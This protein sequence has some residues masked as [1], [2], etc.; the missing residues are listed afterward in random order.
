MLESINAFSAVLSTEGH[1]FGLC[2]AQLKPEGPD[3]IRKEAWW[4]Y[5][6]ISGVRLCWELEEPKGP[7]GRTLKWHRHFGPALP[8]G[9]LR[10]C[11]QKSTCIYAINFRAICGAHRVTLLPIFGGPRNIRCPPS[12]VPPCC[13]C[14]RIPGSAVSGR[15]LI[16]RFLNRQCGP[17]LIGKRF[18][19]ERLGTSPT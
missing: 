1:I 10:P 19:S 7:R 5:R 6:T 13:C 17:V 16:D 12:S 14:S 11:H 2:W 4:F 9:G 3:V 18:G 15:S 8:H